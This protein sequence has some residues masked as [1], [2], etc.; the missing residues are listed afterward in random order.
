M[1]K[2][3]DLKMHER[4]IRGCIRDYVTQ[5]RSRRVL[6]YVR[7]R[8]ELS[9]LMLVGHFGHEIPSP[10]A[11]AMG[12]AMCAKRS[13]PEATLQLD[14]CDKGRWHLFSIILTRLHAAGKIRRLRGG[15]YGALL[16]RKK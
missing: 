8:G 5:D 7:E 15:R 6:E 13:R 4:I 10:H 2:K 14:I 11:A 12:R 1:R 9:P 16:E 3:I